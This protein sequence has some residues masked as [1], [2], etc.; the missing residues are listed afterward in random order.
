MKDI[1]EIQ[2]RIDKVYESIVKEEKVFSRSLTKTIL[3]Y[4][5]IVVVMVGYT[6]YLNIKIHELATPK[7]LAITINNSI[8][9]MIPRFSQNL[10][11]EMEPRAK[12]A[13]LKSVGLL[14]SGIPY[15]KEM[16]KSQI[17]IY[18]D[19]MA[20]DME[21]EHMVKFESVID[22]ALI[23]VTKNK[24]LAKDKELGKALAAQ[25]SSEMDKELA[26]IIDKPFI[27]AVD[28]FRLETEALRN[29]PTSKLTRK[30]FAEKSFIATWIYLVDNKAPDKGVF[31]KVIQLVNETSKNL[32][33]AM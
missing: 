24:D 18:V 10:K 8:K 20:L 1:K 33:D 22:E 11:N 6:V 4:L 26:K 16:L 21:K 28:K 25:L 31:S 27:D 17:N 23:K 7:N 29:K 14:H 9:N 2:E 32:Q 19:K 15:I 30:E 12:Q 5:V 3:F 13:A